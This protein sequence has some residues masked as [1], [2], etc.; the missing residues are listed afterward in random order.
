MRCV[1][2]ESSIPVRVVAVL[3]RRFIATRGVKTGAKLLFLQ[4]I[5][6]I[7]RVNQPGKNPD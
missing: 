1:A 3:H 6:S 5:R 2:G 4:F 7:E